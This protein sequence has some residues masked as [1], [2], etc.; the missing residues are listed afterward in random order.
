M[1]DGTRAQLEVLPTDEAAGFAPTLLYR[2]TPLH[3][4][5]QPYR[6]VLPL[7]GAAPDLV[8]LFG[9]GLGYTAAGALHLCPKARVVAWEPVPEMAAIARDVL[10]REWN[11]GASVVLE[12]DL[13]DFQARLIEALRRARSAA[14]VELSALAALEP[15]HAASFRD[16]VRAAIDATSLAQGAELDHAQLQNIADVAP[17]LAGARS[18]AGLAGAL[19]GVPGVAVPTAPDA[20]ALASIRALH[21]SCCVV[22]TAE[23]APALAAGGAAPDVIVVRR[24]GPPDA[25]QWAA[26]AGAVLALCP[27]SHPDWWTAPCAARLALLHTATP[28][29]DPQDELGPRATFAWGDELP[30]ILAALHLGLGP[31]YVSALSYGDDARWNLLSAPVRR[32]MLL[33]RWAHAAS[34]ELR[35]L[36]PAGAPGTHHAAA[37]G[38]FTAALAAGGAPFRGP[39]LAAATRALDTLARDLAHAATLAEPARSAYVTRRAESDT[40]T[41]ALTAPALAHDGDLFAALDGARTLLAAF[42][43]PPRPAP[44]A[45]TNE[46]VRVFIGALP[47]EEVPARVLLAAI[48]RHTHARLA[49]R[50]VGPEIVDA[51]GPRAAA[52]PR[53][54]WPFLVPALCGHEGRALYVEPSVLVQG[55]VLDAWNAPLGPNVALVPSQGPVSLAVIDAGRAPWDAPFLERLLAGQESPSALLAAGSAPGIGALPEAWQARDEAPLLASAIRFTCEPWLPW[56]RDL[57]PAAWIWEAAFVLAANQDALS[58]NEIQRAEAQG[59]VRAGFAEAARSLAGATSAVTR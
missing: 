4:R 33:R 45:A 59:H 39:D 5:V 56:K 30:V 10:Q 52:L 44:P 20:A 8:I 2:D 36:P 47:G 53:A 40:F 34:V 23:A 26:A 43:E 9:V 3:D 28:W 24:A 41:R 54:Y 18:F 29:L 19:G 57:H 37:P 27:E 31:L 15:A 42:G 38:R 25:A 12:E 58:V 1:P 46:T 50:F 32:D 48:E 6:E 17:H 22:A 16:A 7:E 13:A 51:L 11:L 21:A 49:V 35:E 14:V 55:D